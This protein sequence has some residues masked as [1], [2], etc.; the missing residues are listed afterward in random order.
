[1]KSNISRMFA[2]IACVT[3]GAVIAVAQPAAA[4]SFN[5]EAIADGGGFTDTN[6]NAQIGAEGDWGTIVG[7]GIGILDVGSGISVTGSASNSTGSNTVDAYFDSGSAGLGVCSGFNGSQCAPSN[8]DNIG[9]IGGSA[10]VGNGSFET[11]ILKFSELVNLTQIVFAGE[12]HGEFHGSVEING[13][14]IDVD[15]VGTHQG[16][17]SVL[18]TLLTGLVFNFRYILEASGTANE[19]YI[20]GATVSAVPLPAALPLFGGALSVMG[21][22]GW[23][24]KRAS[25]AA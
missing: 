24:R 4:A 17:E 18:N 21:F 9:P 11:L 25:A 6:N 5:F 22:L 20:A 13:N 23:R 2:G 12:G 15:A 7:S 19:L 10:N 16:S 1:M 3:F 8:D 14:T